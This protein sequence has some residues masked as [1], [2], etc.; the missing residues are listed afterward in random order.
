MLRVRAL[1]GSLPAVFRIS[2]IRFPRR[3]RDERSSAVFA[4]NILCLIFGTAFGTNFIIHKAIP[5]NEHRN[6]RRQI[7]NGYKSYQKQENIHTAH[8]AV[9]IVHILAFRPYLL[10]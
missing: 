2:G 7:L 10:N 4:V 3:R 9:I 1:S 8:F 6:D 5:L